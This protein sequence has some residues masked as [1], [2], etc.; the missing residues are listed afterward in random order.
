M[1]KLLTHFKWFTDES[2]PSDE[3]AYRVSCCGNSSS[4]FLG[5]PR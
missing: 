2:Q 3:R 4:S 1:A 5:L